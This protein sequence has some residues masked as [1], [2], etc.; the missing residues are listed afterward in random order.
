MTKRSTSE[1]ATM[2]EAAYDYFPSLCLAGNNQSGT[3]QLYNG[4]KRHI[5]I[6]HG[7]V[8]QML[9]HNII[10]LEYLRYKKNLADPLTKGLT[11]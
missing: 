5:H 7:A 2:G 10:S 6:R 3:Q 9:K 4:K 11:R 1:Y 8:K